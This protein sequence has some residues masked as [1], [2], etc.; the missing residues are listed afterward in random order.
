MKERESQLKER[1]SLIENCVCRPSQFSLPPSHPSSSLQCRAPQEA[2]LKQLLEQ[3]DDGADH[4]QQNG[5][6][7]R[8]GGR[9]GRKEWVKSAR[10]SIGKY[11]SRKYPQ[12]P[13]S[14]PPAPSL[15]PTI[16]TGRRGGVLVVLGG[17]L[18]D[19]AV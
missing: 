17:H 12:P 7:R 16:F 9:K 6:V 14:A 8:K 2:T 19:T 4:A 3:P 1:M 13:T 15:S 10:Q 5:K 11:S 18:R